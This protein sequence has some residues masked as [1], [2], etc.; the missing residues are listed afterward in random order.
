MRGRFGLRVDHP[1]LRP[2]AS[3]EAVGA[4]REG[5][6]LRE[7]SLP[8]RGRHDGN[9]PPFREPAE[10]MRRLRI[11]Q[12]IA[13][14]V[15]EQ[16][17]RAFRAGQRGEGAVDVSRGDSGGQAAIRRSRRG[18]PLRNIGRGRDRR[19]RDIVGD[20][21][22]H[23]PARERKH[24]PKRLFDRN[25]RAGSILDVRAVA[26]RRGIDVA[27]VEPAIGA[28]LQIAATEELLRHLSRQQQQCGAGEIGVHRAGQRVGRPGAAGDQ[29]HARLAC[30][31]VVAIRHICGA[32]LVPADHISEFGAIMQPLQEVH[33]APARDAEYRRHALERQIVQKLIADRRGWGCCLRRHAFVPPPISP[34]ATCPARLVGPTLNGKDFKD[35]GGWGFIMRYLPLW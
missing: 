26:G 33:D 32:G 18:W 35:N 31:P 10:R 28:L 21:E 4:Q 30:R 5:V 15:A 29:H 19:R 13:A 1:I 11:A 17:K 25:R 6:V 23:G 16:N 34:C 24:V 12:R 8:V 2:R 14:T 22:M 7:G 3:G 20:R 9:V 27:D